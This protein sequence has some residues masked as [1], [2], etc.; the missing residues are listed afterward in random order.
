MNRVLLHFGLN[1]ITIKHL[2][3]GPQTLPRWRK[4]SCTPTLGRK[5][6]SWGRTHPPVRCRLSFLS[7]AAWAVFSLL[8]LCK[9]FCL[10]I[11][12]ARPSSSAVGTLTGRRSCINRLYCAQAAGSEKGACVFLGLG[13]QSKA[14]SPWLMQKRNFLFWGGAEESPSIPQHNTMNELFCP[15]Q[16]LN[17]TFFLVV[18]SRIPQIALASE[19]FP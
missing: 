11:G 12:S 19:T 6:I 18:F 10:C 3:G 13:W 8:M 7:P 15:P 2:F 14:F 1:W 9:L 5:N 16:F 4:S 17:Y